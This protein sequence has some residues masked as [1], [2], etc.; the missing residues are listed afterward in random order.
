MG[1]PSFLFSVVVLFMKIMNISNNGD[2]KRPGNDRNVYCGD[3]ADRTDDRERFEK[4]PSGKSPL[5]PLRLECH[6]RWRR[7]RGGSERNE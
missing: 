5:F 3:S 4:S 6:E 7:R 1:K 2:G